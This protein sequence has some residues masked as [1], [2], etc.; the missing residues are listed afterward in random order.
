MVYLKACPKCLGDL[1]VARDG[2]GIFFSCLQCGFM[3]DIDVKGNPNPAVAQTTAT[4]AW[5]RQSNRLPKAA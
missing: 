4:G 1:T 2:Y 3:R 5:N